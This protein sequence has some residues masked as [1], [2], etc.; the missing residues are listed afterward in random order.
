MR[1]DTRVVFNTYCADLAR[2]NGVPDATQR[3]AVD[4][5]VE[6]T[7]EN[8]IQQ[9]ADFLKRVNVVGVSQPSGQVLGLGATGPVAGRTD[10][11]A[12]E[13]QPR[14]VHGLGKRQYRTHQTN[15]DT[16]VTYA[17][18]DAWAKFPDFQ[19]RIRNKVIEQIARDRLMIGWQG[20]SVADDTD[21]VA[22]P[23]LQDVNIGWLQYLRDTD[24]TRVFTGPKVGD[25]GDYKTLD[26]LI[27]DAVNTY[28]DDW[29][30]TDGEIVALTASDLISER[31]LG[32]I[33]D[34]ANT[35][36]E[37]VALKTLMAGRA[38]GGRKA[39]VVPFFP[40][41]TILLTNPR[42]L[43]IYWQTGTRR[44]HIKD[45]PERDR[46]EDFQSV[47]ECYVIEDTGACCLIE[48]ILQ[49]DGAGGW[50]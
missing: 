17:T 34:N 7:L 12:A 42:N 28:L 19:T 46:I 50:A 40:G 9:S 18:L 31:E 41:R 21:L 48:G 32:L 37:A 35:P 49:P 25:G 23:L 30:K 29:Y 44:R 36:T 11:S 45:K 27:H 47:N 13:R 38:V 43:S 5:T 4:P 33:E 16:Y 6:Q 22:N 10:T 15:F 39:Q 20:V 24:A 1:N 14:D 2:L 8:R 26:G 3:F